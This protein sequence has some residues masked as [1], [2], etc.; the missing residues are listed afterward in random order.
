[1][2][3]QPLENHKTVMYRIGLMEFAMERSPYNF[4]IQLRL[5]KLYDALHL[6]PSFNQA[7]LNLNPKG[8]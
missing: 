7:I 5:L 8:V 1:M 6:S 3:T 2:E 4:D